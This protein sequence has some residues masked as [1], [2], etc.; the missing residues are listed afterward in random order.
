[1]CLRGHAFIVE[2]KIFHLIQLF[3]IG[4]KD[5]IILIIKNNLDLLSSF[6]VL[7]LL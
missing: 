6:D 2:E 7:E 3:F 1:L 4:F 5:I